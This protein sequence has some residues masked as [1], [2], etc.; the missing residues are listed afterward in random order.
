MSNV[1]VSL[2]GRLSLYKLIDKQR[3]RRFYLFFCDVRAGRVG[4]GRGGHA[5]G[6]GDMTLAPYLRGAALNCP[7]GAVSSGPGVHKEY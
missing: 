2:I 5:L 7:N 6:Q 3:W 4:R 1:Q